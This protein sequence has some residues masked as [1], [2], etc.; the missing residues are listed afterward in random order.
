MSNQS[1]NSRNIFLM[2]MSFLDELFDNDEVDTLIDDEAAESIIK[3][4][5]KNKYINAKATAKVPEIHVEKAWQPAVYARAILDNYNSTLTI[6][7]KDLGYFFKTPRFIDE[8]IIHTTATRV[9]SWNGDIGINQAH[10]DLIKWHVRDNGWSDIGYHYF[11][12]RLG[13]ITVCRPLDNTGAHTKGKNTGTV[14]I[15]LAGG[16]GGSETDAFTEHYS[17]KQ[18]KT[19]FWLINNLMKFN[20][21]INKLSGHNQYAAKAC[22]CFSVPAFIQENKNHLKYPTRALYRT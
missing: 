7:T 3:K 11:I 1:E 12:N 13:Q 19:F 4:I 9:G 5:E 14:G 10:S 22:P 18:F 20:I 16:F 15:A 8:I 2:L 17:A 21:N 6:Q